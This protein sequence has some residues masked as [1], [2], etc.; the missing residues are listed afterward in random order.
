M[1]PMSV[2]F[3][4][5]IGLALVIGTIESYLLEPKGNPSLLFT[6][7]ALIVFAMIMSGASHRS[8]GKSPARGLLFSIIAG[9]VGGALY[10]QLMRAIGPGK[11]TPYVALVFFAAGVLLSNVIINTV[12]MKAGGFS[13]ADYFR[14]SAKLHWIG[15]LGGS[16]W[17]LALCFNVIASNVRT[18]DFLCAGPRRDVGCGDLGCVHLARKRQHLIYNID[19]YRLCQR[20]YFD[21]RCHSSLNRSL[22]TNDF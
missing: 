12:F 17:M 1:P 14:G 7:V 16:I 3:P 15:I 5:G 20:N 21:R 18:G 10:P 19:V 13:Y 9:C 4:V 6:G 22:L 8:H 11:L 2:A